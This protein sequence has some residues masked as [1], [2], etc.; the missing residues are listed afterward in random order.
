MIDYRMQHRPPDASTGAPLHDVTGNDVYPA[1]FYERPDWYLAHHKS[2]WEAIGK[3]SFARGKP[4][5]RIWIY[6]SVPRGVRLIH[7]GDWVAITKSYA[8]DEGR[9]PTDSSEDME[10]LTARVRAK[11]I[12]TAGD[13]FQEW[14]YNG[15]EVLKGT[16]VFRPRKKRAS[17][18]A[19]DV[20]GPAR[21][22]R[23][24]RGLP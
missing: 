24:W 20:L 22:R 4:E 18:T 14:G 1:D 12:H 10:V 6:R 11:D 21:K 8:R 2:D 19:E 15:P 9:H 16:I 5:H 13:S 23:P 7:P 3:I 17:V